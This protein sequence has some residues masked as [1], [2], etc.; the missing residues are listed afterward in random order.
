YSKILIPC[1]SLVQLF[2][3]NYD[4]QTDQEYNQCDKKQ[5]QGIEGDPKQTHKRIIPTQH[6]KKV[7]Y[8]HALTAKVKALVHCGLETKVRVLREKLERENIQKRRIY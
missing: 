8:N 5:I 6:D 3:Y 7:H 1:D 2:P 4:N